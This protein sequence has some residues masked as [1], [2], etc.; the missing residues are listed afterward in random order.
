MP[1]SRAEAGRRS[2][3]PIARTDMAAEFR[4]GSRAMFSRKLVEGLRSELSLGRKAVLL[5]N[6]RGFAKF[7]LC[8]DCG[9]VPTCPSCDTSL[10]YHERGRM[11]VC[12]H[13]GHTE[14]APAVCP[15]CGSPYL[16]KFG[17]GTSLQATKSCVAMTWLR[18]LNVTVPTT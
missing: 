12:H 10:T 7:L 16:K 3:C 17:A 6:Q 14:I 13:C 15:E 11:L 5:L 9:F 8:R 18:C 1:V 4:G 2:I